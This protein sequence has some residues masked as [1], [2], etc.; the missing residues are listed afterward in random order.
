MLADCAG[1]GPN[2]AA[3]ILFWDRLLTNGREKAPFYAEFAH[4]PVQAS[5]A[6]PEQGIS[7][8]QSGSLQTAPAASGEPNRP[9]WY[10]MPASER[11]TWAAELISNVVN[12]ALG[13][14]V[15]RSQPLMMAGL[16]SL[17]TSHH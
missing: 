4:E 11:A 10:Y 16:D 3:A 15:A 12:K 14:E 9:V 1:T 17:G 7:Q 5:A 13:K 8:E 6:V 2:I